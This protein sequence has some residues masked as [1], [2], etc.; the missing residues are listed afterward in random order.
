MI[1]ILSTIVGHA[2]PGGGIK[3]AGEPVIGLGVEGAVEVPHARVAVEPM[4]NLRRGAT[5]RFSGDTEFVS[6]SGEEPIA[7]ATK[8]GRRERASHRQHFVTVGVDSCGNVGA[9]ACEYAGD[10]IEMI[11]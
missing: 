11:I 6:D 7:P 5:L 4:T 1:A 10:H 3:K 8:L 9:G 2:P